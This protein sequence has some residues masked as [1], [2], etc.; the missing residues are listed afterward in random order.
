MNFLET[1]TDLLQGFANSR[2]QI[3]LAIVLLL[4][5][6]IGRILYTTRPRGVR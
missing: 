1:L 5:L 6:S 4:A 3:A 2:W